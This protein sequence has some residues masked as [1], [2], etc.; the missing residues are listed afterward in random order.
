M[1]YSSLLA[2]IIATNIC[3][4]IKDQNRNKP[5]TFHHILNNAS[6]LLVLRSQLDLAQ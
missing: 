3:D 4:H 1:E 6:T 5:L 2:Y